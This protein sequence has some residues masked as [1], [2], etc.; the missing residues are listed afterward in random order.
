MTHSERKNMNQ[1]KYIHSDQSD[2]KN[3]EDDLKNQLKN[4]KKARRKSRLKS[5][6][7]V[8]KRFLS[9]V[10]PV[11]DFSNTITPLSNK[12]EFTESKLVYY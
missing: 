11:P 10:K 4:Q 6:T 2:Q 7:K 3:S 9:K 12:Y 5:Q 1:L 8:K